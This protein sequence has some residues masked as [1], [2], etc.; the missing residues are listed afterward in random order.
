[1][2]E[3]D[4]TCRLS[5]AINANMQWYQSTLLYCAMHIKFKY[6]G[7]G[8]HYVYVGLYMHISTCLH[9]HAYIPFTSTRTPAS[10]H[11]FV[12]SFIHANTNARTDTH[13]HVF[14]LNHAQ[15]SGTSLLLRIILAHSLAKIS[16]DAEA[17]I[18]PSLVS[19]CQR[20]R[21]LLPATGVHRV[22]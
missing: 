4:A 5:W 10:I 18:L 13:R 22:K 20:R 7:L 19:A 9:K 8:L 21:Q 17:F 12:R 15:R 3:I 14:L 1:M 16:D 11:S 2:A 6:V